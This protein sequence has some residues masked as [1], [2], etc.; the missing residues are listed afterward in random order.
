MWS[1]TVMQK[2]LIFLYSQALNVKILHKIQHIQRIM[3]RCLL[4]I[5][6]KCM[7]VHI[8]R[9]IFMIRAADIVTRIDLNDNPAVVME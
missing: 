5:K 8:T 9:G 3:E 4:D 1:S 7:Y 6:S 2:L